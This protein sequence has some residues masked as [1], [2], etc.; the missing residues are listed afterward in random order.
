MRSVVVAMRK[1]GL[2][3]SSAENGWVGSTRVGALLCGK[4]LCRQT[5]NKEPEA[6]GKRRWGFR[7]LRMRC[8]INFSNPMIVAERLVPIMFGV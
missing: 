5:S 4:K 7:Q 1:S 3:D 2:L 8:F 6:S